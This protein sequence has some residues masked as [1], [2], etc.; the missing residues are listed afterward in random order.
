VK[1]ELPGV[2][3]NLKDHGAVVLEFTA[4]YPNP[5]LLPTM[6]TRAKIEDAL[7]KYQSKKRTGFFTNLE[8]QAQALLVSS[9]AKAEGQGMWPDIQISFQM[10][11]LFGE[12][13]PQMVY[14]HTVLNRLKSVGEIGLNATAFLE[15]EEDDTKLA[16][17][18]HR[19]FSEESDVEA[20]IDGNFNLMFEW[21]EMFVYD[22]F[23]FVI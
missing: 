18:D 2:G 11:P 5:T 6:T 13:G 10:E 8:A 3:Q 19:L 20:L 14:M 15:G 21:E 1:H 17:V 7:V 22:L 9:R 12:E 23:I 4:F 16:L